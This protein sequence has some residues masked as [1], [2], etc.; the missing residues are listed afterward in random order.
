[1]ILIKR[2]LKNE[3]NSLEKQLFELEGKY[4]EETRDFGNILTGWNQYLSL[5]RGKIRKQVSNDERLFSLSSVTSL[6]S[7][8]EKMKKV[9]M[10]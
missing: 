9:I 2:R 3:L 6:C 10:T 4:L 1:M 8:R 7:S 5:E